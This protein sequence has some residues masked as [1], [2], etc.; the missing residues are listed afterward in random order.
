MLSVQPTCTPRAGRC[1]RLVLS[2]AFIGARSASSSRVP[3]SLCVRAVLPL[4][5]PLPNR[6]L[7][8]ASG[9][10]SLISSVERPRPGRG[11]ER[12]TR[13]GRRRQPQAHRP[14]CGRWCPAHRRL[15]RPLPGHSRRTACGVRIDDWGCAAGHGHRHPCVLVNR[16]GRSRERTGR[17]SAGHGPAIGGQDRPARRRKHAQ[18][19][20]RSVIAGSSP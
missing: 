4:I 8:V 20:C 2:W 16:D 1:A 18:P 5:R 19:Y 15:R 11:S 17:G 3:A 10:R 9:R 7:L 14:A 6:T 12:R 13:P